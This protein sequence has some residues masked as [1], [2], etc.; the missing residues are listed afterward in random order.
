MKRILLILISAVSVLAA[1]S[2][3][4]ALYVKKGDVCAKYN[5]GVAGDLKFSNGGR[6]LSITG[7]EESIKLDEIDYISFSAPLNS[8]GLT[9][10]QSKERIIEIGEKL[11]NKI[12]V[13]SQEENIKMLDVFI[14]K[15]LNYYLD[16]QY[17]DVHTNMP[18]PVVGLFKGLSGLAKGDLS[19]IRRAKQNGVELYQIS[20]YFGVFE[21]DNAKREWVKISDADYLELRFAKY[22]VKLTQSAQYTDWTE[23]DFVGRIP[24]TINVKAVTGTQELFNVLIES[25]INN[26]SKSADINMTVDLSAGYKV[27]NKMSI[28][29]SSIKDD[30]TFDINGERILT[31]HSVLHGNELTNY[32][33]WKEDFNNTHGSDEYYDENL[34]QWIYVDDTRAEMMAGHITYATSE[35]DLF[36]ELQVKGRVSSISKLY[37][38]FSEDSYYDEYREEWD[39]NTNTMT[40]YE[41]DADI[42]DRQILHMNNYSDIS[43]YYDKQP[44]IQG[45][46]AWDCEES[47]DKWWDEDLQ[48]DE[49]LGEY[50]QG[51]PHW[52]RDLYYEQM[53]LLTFPD[54]TTFAIEDYFNES[55]FMPLVNDY[56][57]IIDTYFTI[58]GNIQ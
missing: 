53:P 35:A 4:K 6:V 8:I 40:R 26:D 55:N 20:D 21:A 51:N 14:R 12:D 11:N 47:E 23:V 48:W 16:A 27:V 33:N 43:F 46:V 9:P 5:F 54:M 22:T 28:N 17:Y 49:E 52:V 7:Y 39:E 10:T 44:N 41:N 18:A 30:V 58:S 38:I 25:E 2:F 13:Y 37:D 1:Y 50:V 32:D 3:P 34:N 24:K 56:N 19:G 45:Y 29:N 31:T 36:N 42:V 15:Y 57:A